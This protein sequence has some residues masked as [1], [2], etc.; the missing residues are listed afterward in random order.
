LKLEEM[1]EVESIEA[2]EKGCRAGSRT[3]P[4]LQFQRQRKTG[5][6][7]S[8]GSRG[9]AFRIKFVEPVQGPIAVGY[10][11]HFGLGLFVPADS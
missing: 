7:K 2:V 9:Y 11:S 4:C 8:A 6:G 3:I 5:K 1:P 10:S